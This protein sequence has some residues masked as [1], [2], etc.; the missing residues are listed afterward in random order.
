MEMNYGSK[1]T[2]EDHPS[3]TSIDEGAK[4]ATTMKSP[5]CCPTLMHA[6]KSSHPE[7]IDWILSH[8]SGAQELF[9]RQNLRLPKPLHEAAG[10]KPESGNQE[11]D[12]TAGMKP[13]CMMCVEA[14]LAA[15][16]DAGC[17]DEGGRSPL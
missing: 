5:S 10:A 16:A 6:A 7:C 17:P 4:Y 15:G 13:S 11:V 3:A 1:P 8:G 9:R 12:A 14:L 2:G